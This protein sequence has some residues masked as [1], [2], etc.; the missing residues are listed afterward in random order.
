MWNIFY[1][2]KSN[3]ERSSFI[4][5]IKFILVVTS[6]LD[7]SCEKVYMYLR[8]KNLEKK[9]NLL[10]LILSLST[11]TTFNRR[12]DIATTFVR[13]LCRSFL[14]Q[15]QKIVYA[16]NQTN[17]YEIYFRH[18][19]VKENWV[20]KLI[21]INQLID[22]FNFFSMFSNL[23]KFVVFSSRNMFCLFF[24]LS[25]QKSKTCLNLCRK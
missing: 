11:S 18:F 22:V 4:I 25:S 2:N 5:I 14:Y 10:S 20:N 8:K 19:R 13:S 15:I 21:F 24:D 9:K 23:R 16:T 12:R 3:D 6:S 17:V 1:I 7:D